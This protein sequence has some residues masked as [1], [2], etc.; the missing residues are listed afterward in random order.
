MSNRKIMVLTQ[1]GREL[2]EK[3]ASGQSVGT[4]TE[5]YDEMSLAGMLWEMTCHR[6]PQALNSL[7]YQRGEPF[8][9]RLEAQGFIELVSDLYDLEKSFKEGENLRPFE[10]Y[11]THTLITPEGKKLMDNLVEGVKMSP[12]EK[13]DSRKLWY[14]CRDDV[15][16]LPKPGEVKKLLSKGYVAD[17][18]EPVE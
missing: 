6:V 5:G 4:T 2:V 18:V 10:L 12:T 9:H 16:Q 3:V 14:L 8:I 17:S 7:R 1:K 11:P 13:A 15:T